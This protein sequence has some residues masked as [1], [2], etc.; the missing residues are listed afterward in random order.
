MALS[1]VSLLQETLLILSNLARARYMGDGRGRI[2]SGNLTELENPGLL[3]SDNDY[4][5]A[6]QMIDREKLG[7]SN[8]YNASSNSWDIASSN[9]LP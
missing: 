6:V 8:R 4:R 1:P 5:E 2:E 3:L 9:L 7:R